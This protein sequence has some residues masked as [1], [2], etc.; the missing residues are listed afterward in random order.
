MP[1]QTAN[2]IKIY[3]EEQGQGEPLILINGLAFPMD[4]WF[5]QIRE[6]SK[7]FRVIALDN[8][9]IG[10]SDQPDEEYSIP[11]MAADAVGYACQHY[12]RPNLHF[13]QASSASLPLAPASFD[14]VTAFEV[15]EHVPDWPAALAEFRAAEELD[16]GNPLYPAGAGVALSALGRREEARELFE[17]LLACR[18]RPGLLAEHIDPRSG[19]QWGNF[20]Q[21]YSMV[22][23]I[24]AA[25]R[26]SI[27][28]DQA[29]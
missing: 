17:K 29:F 18:N 4:L 19:E 11:L 7:D 9:G 27:R 20:A 22:G 1:H 28:W 23:L 3:Y 24:N 14:L 2:G 13:L 6:L 5:A 21:T 12:S 26:L 10:R 25:T 16:P 8:R 15:I